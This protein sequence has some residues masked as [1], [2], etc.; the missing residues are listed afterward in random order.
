MPSRPP[1][2]LCGLLLLAAVS[3][4]AQDSAEEPRDLRADLL[5]AIEENDVGAARQ[6]IQEGGDGEINRGNPSPLATAVLLDN[7]NM[8]ALL[9]RSG[10]D[11]NAVEDEPLEHAL[12]N[13]SID[14]VRLLFQAGAKLPESGL[15]DVL[16]VTLRGANGV[17]IYR[18]LLARGTD[19]NQ[20]LA[21]AVAGRKLEAALLCLERGADVAALGEANVFDLNGVTPDTTA[22][23]FR[24]AVRED[25]RDAA[26]SYFLS[27]AAAEGSRE[28]VDR[29][30]ASGGRISLAHLERAVER[31][32]YD[33]ALY[34]IERMDEDLSALLEGAKDEG[35][36]ELAAYL[37]GLR[38]ERIGS[39]VG[40]VLAAAALALVLVIVAYFLRKHILHSPRRL[41]DAVAKSDPKR[42]E[43]LLRSGADPSARY[44]GETLLHAATRRGDLKI[45][46]LLLRWQADASRP[47]EAPSAEAGLTPL[48]AAA[49]R[50]N[51]A[52]AEVLL[53]YGAELDARGANGATPLD[54][55]VAAGR[56]E[57]ASL[58]R[59]RGAQGGGQALPQAAPPPVAQSAA[60]GGQ[61]F[62]ALVIPP[63][64]PPEPAAREVP[65]A[66]PPPSPPPPRGSFTIPMPGEPPERGEP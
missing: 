45:A 13:D 60:A 3:V 17:A 29:A 33:L 38:N 37:E 19:V 11:P 41:Y 21:A 59:E 7:L 40:P 10:G 43:E 64:D 1:F 23:I 62:D 4:A 56:D 65:S 63:P 61:R 52:L 9:L 54:L 30:L 47:S 28:L 12:R 44:R 20:A 15:E 25:N 50:G 42:L 8:V 24:L 53:R 14:M 39:V 26:L 46:R 51:V 16:Q 22:E 18:E 5:L 35:R 57:I 66:P 2:A 58:L 27:V 55:A 48:H 36:S 34:L 31:G 6:V 32:R 49:G